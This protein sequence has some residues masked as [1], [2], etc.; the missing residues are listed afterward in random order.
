M[1]IGLRVCDLR[2]PTYKNKPDESCKL[3][4]TLSNKQ[5]IEAKEGLFIFPPSTGQLHDP[6][7]FGKARPVALPSETPARKRVSSSVFASFQNQ[8]YLCFD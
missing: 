2:I 3:E 7:P 5:I 4:R 1:S 8:K 6:P